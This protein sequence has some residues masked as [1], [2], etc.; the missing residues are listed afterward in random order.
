M[1]LV[2][3][4]AVPVIS[5]AETYTYDVTGRLTSVTYDD[6]TTITY[7][8]DN[9]GNILE[10]RV[11]ETPGT[12][13]DISASPVNKDFG[14]IITGNSSTPQIFTVS[15]TGTDDLV[16]GA[17][18]LT[19]TAA[20]EFSIQND[21]C[22]GKTLTPSG[23][24]TVEALFSPATDGA[25][26]ANLSIP[27][28]DPDTPTLNVL[29]SGT[30]GPTPCPESISPVS[31]S[32]GL[33]GGTDS[34]AVVA[35]GSCDWTAASSNP[36]WLKTTSGGSGTGDG[37]VNY[38]VSPNTGASSRTATITITGDTSKVL[39]VSQAGVETSP[40]PDIKANGS[41]G[42]VT[43]GTSD[44]LS[45]SVSLAANGSLGVECDLWLIVNTPTGEWE[46]F[47]LSLGVYTPG[48]MPSL[49]GFSLVDF[50]STEIFNTSGSGAG[51]YT[52]YIAVD[53]GG[54]KL[55]W[56]S[57]VVTVTDEPLPEIYAN[58]SGGTVNIN[59]GDPLAIA[60]GLSSNNYTGT[61]A[62][63]WIVVNTPSGWQYYDLAQGTFTPGLMASLPGVSLVDFGSTVIFNTSGS[64]AGTYTYYFLVDLGGGQVFFK[65]VVVI[66]NISP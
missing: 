11:L 27:S 49:Q 1:W 8:Y 42:Q 10:T 40:A 23:D 52:Y 21:T 35:S 18:S 45:V 12:A 62:D 14:E 60:I 59:E 63:W 47:D 55:F 64:G 30:G 3:C 24:C 4:L 57:V 61:N 6:S 38:T 17:L 36:S 29:L 5:Q 13:P 7:T 51:T 43:L 37:T 53:L 54:G 32:F 34:V 50:G 44:S 56:D 28:N 19:G 41:D 9:A 26:S 65:S 20:S 2:M 31:K 16:I 66:V 58:G 25:K 46:Y 33:D 15:N 48:L 39:T 22:S